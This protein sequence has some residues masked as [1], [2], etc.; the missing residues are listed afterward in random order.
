MYVETE[1]SSATSATAAFEVAA[2][3]WLGRLPAP[4]TASPQLLRRTSS[5]PRLP[6]TTDF[7]GRLRSPLPGHRRPS[8]LRL[9]SL[10]SLV[11]EGRQGKEEQQVTIRCQRMA[12]NKRREEVE[13][14]LPLAIYNNLVSGD[15][16]GERG[17]AF[18]RLVR[19]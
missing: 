19:V 17:R 6:S 3:A 16:V 14:D 7:W 12:T 13:V 1:A 5:A 9:P 2:L 18:R 15:V 4:T 10:P 8:L 11:R